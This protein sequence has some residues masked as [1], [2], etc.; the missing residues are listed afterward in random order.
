[1]TSQELFYVRNH[2]AVPAVPDSQIPDWEISI[3]GSACPSLFPV[4]PHR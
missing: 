4:H 3:E 2:G 1:M